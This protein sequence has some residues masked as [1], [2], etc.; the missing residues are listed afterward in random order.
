MKKAL[1]GKY[2]FP[3]LWISSINWKQ[4]FYKSD[5]GSQCNPSPNCNDIPYRNRKFTPK[6]HMDAQRTSDI[7]FQ[8]KRTPLEEPPRRN[9]SYTTKNS[10]KHHNTGIGTDTQTNNLRYITQSFSCFNSD[11]HV[12]KQW[13][14]ENGIVTCRRR[15][16]NGHFSLSTN[17]TK[18][19]RSES[20]RLK[21]WGGHLKRQA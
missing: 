19:A 3:W 9:S 16:P 14:W 18:D 2:S 12:R 8:I 4:L 21:L 6:T 15:K 1:E 17:W 13:G 20:L 5:K 7:Q 10:N 11:R